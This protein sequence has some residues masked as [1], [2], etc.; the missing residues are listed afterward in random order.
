MNTTEEIE[1]SLRVAQETRKYMATIMDKTKGI[2]GVGIIELLVVNELIHIAINE[3]KE[4]NEMLNDFLNYLGK[5]YYGFG[6]VNAPAPS[7][8]N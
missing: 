8:I 1:E 3:R 5:K 7:S 6:K 2:S 4:F